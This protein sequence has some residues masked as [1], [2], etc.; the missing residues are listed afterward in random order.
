MQNQK[1]ILCYSLINVI[2][3]YVYNHRMISWSKMGRG[4][5][6]RFP[7]TLYIHKKYFFDSHS[8]WENNITTIFRP[9]QI[10]SPWVVGYLTGCYG[11]NSDEYSAINHDR[12][13]VFSSRF[14]DF[15]Y[16]STSPLYTWVVCQNQIMSLRKNEI[17]H[18]ILL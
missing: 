17:V 9:A 3:Y 5:L 16:I 6:V 1:C 11:E 4:Y 2:Y 12:T 18:V 8:V 15:V 7:L 13:A 14:R 10:D